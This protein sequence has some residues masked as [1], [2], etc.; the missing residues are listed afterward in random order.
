LDDRVVT[1][2]VVH[3]PRHYT[4]HAHPQY[5]ID[6]FSIEHLSEGTRNAT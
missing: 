6:C 1:S 3:A 2:G 4:Q 5:S